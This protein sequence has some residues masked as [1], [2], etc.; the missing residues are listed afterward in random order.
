[1][2]T[3]PKCSKP[4]TK[5][6]EVLGQHQILQQWVHHKF[7]YSTPRTVFDP[8]S[9]YVP[10]FR[11]WPTF[12]H[13]F[14]YFDRVEF[15]LYPLVNC[16]ITMENHRFQWANPLS[17]AIFNS[18]VWHN[19]RVNHVP[20]ETNGFPSHRAKPSSH[21]DMMPWYRVGGGISRRHLWR[22][23]PPDGNWKIGKYPLVN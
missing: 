5:H 18:Y 9:L 4:P 21:Q 17:M 3:N 20:V 2:E 13:S 14:R 16:P 11:F 6:Q 22:Q 12:Q 10:H 19:Q 7:V 15:T 1:M 8:V 23:R